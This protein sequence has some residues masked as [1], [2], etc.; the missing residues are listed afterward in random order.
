MFFML[1][2]QIAER[3][4]QRC[5]VCNISLTLL[6]S[7]CAISKSFIYDL[8]KRDKSPSADKLKKIADFLDCSVDYL[9]GR[10]DNPDS[11]KK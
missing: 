6:I 4:K 2:S 9:M 11:H 7:N 5:K 10:T 1:N 8:E 3:I